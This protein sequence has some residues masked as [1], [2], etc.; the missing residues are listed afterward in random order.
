MIEKTTNPKAS[1]QKKILP[2]IDGTLNSGERADFEAYVATHPEFESLV[3]EKQQEV[4][5]LRDLMPKVSLSPEARESLESE[6]RQ[7]IFNLLK[8][9]PK[10]F[11]DKIKNRFEEWSNR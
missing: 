9:E 3:K 4:S 2:Y 8:E 6:I 1:Y 7:S 10:S 5:F 11:M